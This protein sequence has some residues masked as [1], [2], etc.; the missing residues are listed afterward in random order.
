[1]TGSMAADDA[2][3]SLRSPRGSTRIRTSVIEGSVVPIRANPR[4]DLSGSAPS[5]AIP[6]GYTR[7]RRRAVFNENFSGDS[8]RF[9]SF[10]SIGI[11]I[12]AVGVARSVYGA[13]MWCPRTF[14]MTS[15]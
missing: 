5:A 14:C 1:M 7:T 11:E 12:A 10:Q 6:G 13:T 4:P 9:T 15:T 8:P 2:D 3:V